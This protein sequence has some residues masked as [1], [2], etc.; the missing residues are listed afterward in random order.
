[1]QDRANPTYTFAGQTHANIPSLTKALMTDTDPKSDV[2]HLRTKEIKTAIL[3]E[4]SI[5]PFK[6]FTEPG[7]YLNSACGRLLSL[8]QKSGLASDKTES[9]LEFCILNELIGP[10][11]FSE[12][13]LLA[14]FNKE[15]PLDLNRNTGRI[16][17]KSL[18]NIEPSLY[19]ERA[20]R[21]MD[22]ECYARANVDFMIARKHLSLL[23]EKKILTLKNEDINHLKNELRRKHLLC[24]YM[25][26]DNQSMLE[27]ADALARDH[28]F[29]E[30]HEKV[31]AAVAALENKAN[32]VLPYQ[33]LAYN[34]LQLLCEALAEVQ[35]TRAEPDPL[36][37]RPILDLLEDDDVVELLKQENIQPGEEDNRG[38]LIDFICLLP[39]LTDDLI[40]RLTPAVF[41]ENLTLMRLFWLSKITNGDDLLE[42]P[43]KMKTLSEGYA[44]SYP[45]S[46]FIHYLLAYRYQ[47]A[48]NR[49]EAFEY[50]EKSLAINPYYLAAWTLGEKITLF[51]FTEK[52]LHFKKERY[53]LDLRLNPNDLKTHT[54]HVDFCSKVLHDEE[55]TVAA[56][57][58]LVEARIRVGEENPDEPQLRDYWNYIAQNP[59]ILDLLKKPLPARTFLQIF[60]DLTPDEQ[61]KASSLLKKRFKPGDT[62]FAAFIT[63]RLAIAEDNTASE[64][65]RNNLYFSTIQLCAHNDKRTDIKNLLLSRADLVALF[66]NERMFEQDPDMSHPITGF[67]EKCQIFIRAE[68][69]KCKQSVEEKPAS[70]GF[71]ARLFGGG[72]KVEAPLTVAQSR[73][74]AAGN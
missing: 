26:S 17:T 65:D 22:A 4:L 29:K 57:I 73:P 3:D 18:N 11:T 69:A 10:Y 59:F 72:S 45:N 71:F 21:Y 12:S 74:T 14:Q 2:S 53:K 35:S 46:A 13:D 32:G 31:L 55:A 56:Q 70:P 7:G 48:K 6:Y 34:P 38:L 63:E 61:K 62:E 1:M 51:V 27:C 43:H 39:N 41:Q 47:N 49:R 36:I 5:N 58:A 25:L 33:T 66:S 67:S 54:Y 24:A 40:S 60:L 52:E 16:K 64:D 15:E 30:P 37:M 50:I 28:A 20:L 23:Q 42:R 68:L 19:E 44:E 9:Y 8:Q